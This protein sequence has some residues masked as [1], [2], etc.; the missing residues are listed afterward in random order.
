MGALEGIVAIAEQ[1][2]E[3]GF[4]E[5]PSEAIMKVKPAKR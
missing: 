5:Q 3:M 2:Q 4:F 1:L